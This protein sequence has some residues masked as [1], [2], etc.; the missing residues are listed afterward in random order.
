DVTEKMR[1]AAKAVNFG[2]IY[3]ISSFGLAKNTGIDKKTAGNFIKSYFERYPGV[4]VF[5]DGLIKEAKEKGYVSTIFNRRRYINEF[6]SSNAVERN[7]AERAAVNTSIQGSAADIIKIAMLKINE[8]LKEK[9]FQA[10]MILQVHDELLLE[11]PPMELNLLEE[12]IRDIME[13]VINLN[14]PLKVKISSGKSW[15]EI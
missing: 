9:S 1:N 5:I 8:K 3:G 6:K 4:K 11:V 10:R 12:Q 7:F 14:V 15:A 13:N 2:I